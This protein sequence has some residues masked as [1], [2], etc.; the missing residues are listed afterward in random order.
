MVSCVTEHVRKFFSANLN[1]WSY[2][3]LAIHSYST[4]LITILFWCMLYAL[5]SH[6][7]INMGKLNKKKFYYSFADNTANE[8]KT[9]MYN[10]STYIIITS[11]TALPLINIILNY[12]FS[13]PNKSVLGCIYAMHLFV[14]G[15][16]Y[17]PSVK[18]LVSSEAA[19]LWTNL[20][21]SLYF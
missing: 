5:H 19:L 2:Y 4:Y 6:Y 18:R 16:I 10:L 7:H 3:T 13:I 8:W 20:L 15:D 12:F 17:L 21:L 11:S 9:D 14:E 1:V